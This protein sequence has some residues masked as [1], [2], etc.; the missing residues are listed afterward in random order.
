[1]ARLFTAASRLAALPRD[2]AAPGGILATFGNPLIQAVF[3]ST[4]L[5]RAF[6]V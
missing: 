3:I 5:G 6:A 2:A 4:W 1:V